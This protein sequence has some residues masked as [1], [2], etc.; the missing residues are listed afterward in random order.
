M[1]SRA[2][3]AASIVLCT[4]TQPALRTMDGFK[5]GFDIGDERELAPNPPEL[6]AALKRVTLEKRGP[7]DDETT[8]ARFAEQTQ[9]LC[10][11][12]SRK[13]ARALFDRIR[14]FSGASHLTTL[15]CPRHRRAVLADLRARLAAGEP[16]RLVATSL[17]EAG[18][19]IDFPEVWRAA[20]GLDSIAQAAGRC[21][22]EF[23]L[24]A[25]RV[26]VFE[27]E[28]AARSGIALIRASPP[29][30]GADRNFA[31]GRGPS[32]AG[33]GR[34][35]TGARIE[36]LPVRI[37][38]CDVLRSPPHGGADR[39][40]ADSQPASR[41]DGRLLTGARIETSHLPCSARSSAVASSRGRGSKLGN[42]HEN[43]E[44]HASPPHGGADR[45]ANEGAIMRR[46]L[47][48]S[49]RGADRNWLMTAI[50]RMCACRL[51]GGADRTVDR[52]LHC[53][54]FSDFRDFVE[55]PLSR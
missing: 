51:H 10:I 20:A 50:V 38:P 28:E 27:P 21:N 8:A 41:A 46:T 24:S 18:V 30:G 7:T 32:R 2:T 37:G 44:Q 15:M 22:R 33:R 48:A 35:L 14:D 53:P 43:G 16:V 11:V 12:N 49:S 13:H 29:H 36:T 39:N 6:Y 17:I 1:N 3:T 5:K 9:M 54:L 42:E 45:N 26:V 47:V 4:A 31:R 52:S 25:G 34:L 55:R 19:D 23:R 40:V